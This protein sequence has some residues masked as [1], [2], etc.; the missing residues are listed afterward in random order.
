MRWVGIMGM[1]SGDVL[2]KRRVG[3]L[4]MRVGIL[5]MRRVGIAR[6]HVSSDSLQEG[7][8]WNN[9]G[10]CAP[11]PQLRNVAGVTCSQERHVHTTHS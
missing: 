5:G 8:V 10:I 1:S 2:G 6:R 3:I 4:E 11:L 9:H 7:S